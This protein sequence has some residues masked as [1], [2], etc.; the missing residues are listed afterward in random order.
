MAK[1]KRYKGAVKGVGGWDHYK[2][3]FTPGRRRSLKKAQM[4]ANRNRAKANRNSRPIGTTTG[5][6]SS[7][8]YG[9]A[10]SRN[11]PS[12][13]KRNAGGHTKQ[14]QGYL[15]AQAKKKTLA[16]QKRN[17]TVKN[18]AMVAGIVGAGA[19]G[20]LMVYKGN[21]M[22]RQYVAKVPNMQRAANVAAIRAANDLHATGAVGKNAIKLSP[23]IQGTKIAAK[24]SNLPKP[25][26][27]S[28]LAWHRNDVSYM[29]TNGT[30][31]AAS[32]MKDRVSGTVTQERR[33]AGKRYRKDLSGN[34]A[35]A[36][37]TKAK[38]TAGKKAPSTKAGATTVA[39]PMIDPNAKKRSANT[40]ANGLSDTKVDSLRALVNKQAAEQVSRR[41]L[42]ADKIAARV[43]GDANE[44]QTSKQLSSFLSGTALRGPG[45]S[46]EGFYMNPKKALRSSHVGAYMPVGAGR[47]LANQQLARS[48]NQTWKKLHAANTA[49]NTAA[50]KMVL[51]SW[52]TKR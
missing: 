52:A 37:A 6:K 20:G 33:S 50:W 47:V 44:A 15:S 38:A 27:K 16:R 5:T 32:K 51:Q 12:G 25:N 4:V 28:K 34:S 49:Q 2:R 46:I 41:K 31:R 3:G 19:V 45:G 22:A 43:S 21:Q 9:L 7:P 18:V 35:I 40:P 24:A 36:K 30:D 42:G 8:S 48:G 29:H 1:Y 39:K 14:Y 13:Y 11:A 10:R 23:D 17:E 26:G